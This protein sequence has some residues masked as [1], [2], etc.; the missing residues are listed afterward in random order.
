M[1]VPHVNKMVTDFGGIYTDKCPRFSAFLLNFCVTIKS[2]TL[3]ALKTWVWSRNYS[4]A[5]SF[6]WFCFSGTGEIIEFK[7]FAPMSRVFYSHC[8]SC[9]IMGM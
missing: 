4:D 2:F 3:A 8:D 1:N 9:E 7:L 5:L 6:V